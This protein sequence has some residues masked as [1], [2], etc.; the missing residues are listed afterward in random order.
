MKSILTFATALV[1][2]C[3]LQFGI[4]SCKKEKIVEKTT[5]DT[6]YVQDPMLTTQALTAQPWRV[7]EQ[8]GVLGNT[9]VYYLRGG[10]ANTVNFDNFSLK[11]NA[12]GTGTHTNNGSSLNLT[13]TFA[14]TE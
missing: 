3:L 10:S 8:R 6:V 1:F 2:L 9:V 11:F 13:W 12:D 7:Y 4:S 5:T 14:N